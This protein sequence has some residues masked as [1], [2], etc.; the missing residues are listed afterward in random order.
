MHND[1]R[2]VTVDVG[3]Q[4]VL[5]TQFGQVLCSHV[6]LSFATLGKSSIVRAEGPARTHI[7]A[8]QAKLLP[9]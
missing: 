6:T 9:R 7:T 1:V 4:S 5:E 3:S 2:P 8:K